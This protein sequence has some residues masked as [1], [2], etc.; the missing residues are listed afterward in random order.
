MGGAEGVPE[1]ERAEVARGADVG[2]V[3]RRDAEVV[4]GGVER[5]LLL[6]RARRLRAG[7]EV[8]PLR[9]G[10]GADGARQYPSPA[11][12]ISATATGKYVVILFM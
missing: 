2:D 4:E 7:E 1:R 11:P 3:V 10:A 8:V 9:A 5:L 6:V 12:A